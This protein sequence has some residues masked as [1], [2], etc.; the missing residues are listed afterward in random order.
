MTALPPYKFPP[1]RSYVALNRAVAETAPQKLSLRPA[2]EVLPKRR[3]WRPLR[4]VRSFAFGVVVTALA[5]G[6]C[7]WAFAR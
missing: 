6:G 2:F 4:S 7:V 3:S 1:Q 5:F